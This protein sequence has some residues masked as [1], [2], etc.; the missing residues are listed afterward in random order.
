[1]RII[2]I[3][4]GEVGLHIAEKLCAEKRDVV[5][6]DSQAERLRQIEEQIDAQLM[7]GSG[8]SPDVLRRAGIDGAEMLIAVSDQDE[9]NLVACMLA[10]H[11]SP[12]TVKIARVRNPAYIRMPEVLSGFNL[13]MFINPEY[14]AANKISRLLEV[15]QAVDIVEF[16]EGQV[17]LVG[18]RVEPTS[19]IAN[20]KLF[21]LGEILPDYTPLVAVIYRGKQV[22]IPRGG[23]TLQAG[24]IVYFTVTKDQLPKLLRLIGKKA[25]R[26]EQ[27]MIFSGSNMGLY[28]AQRLESE[29][30]GVKLIDPDESTCTLLADQLTH[31][32]VLYGDAT[33]SE[34]LEQENVSK[35]DAF[36]AAGKDDE[37]NIFACLLAKTLGAPYTMTVANKGDYASLINSLGID[38]AISP[39]L[40]AVSRIMQ[41]LR[42][43]LVVAVEEI[44]H[45]NAEG[46]E[47]VAL[48]T[49]DAVGRPLSDIRF[50]DGA[51]V[52]AVVHEGEVVIPRGDT[53]IRPKDRVVIFAE[54]NA[55][56]KVE[57]L[58][59]VK[60]EY[61]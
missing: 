15:P 32:T 26:V 13:G 57:K 41:F 12:N 33:D 11:A 28:L 10:N 27:V 4:A 44:R 29:G 49:S 14:E 55:I 54:R 30:V 46:I 20:R 37:D 1:M 31:T 45:K 42:K 6:I 3:G 8:S 58:F 17:K 48:E 24:D 39:Q 19:R 61:F 50:P 34:M 36:I 35:M 5:I 47:F 18:F 25:H 21:S 56:A 60:L 53:V 38:S 43:G 51:L 23:D 40:T 16:A 22:I 2:I 9:V 52:I 7:R 59:S